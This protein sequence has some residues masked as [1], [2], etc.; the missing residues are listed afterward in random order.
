MQNILIIASVWPEPNSSAAGARTMELIRVCLEHG[1]SVTVA[2]ASALS[3]HRADLAAIGVAERV[4]ALN[5]DSF[6]EVVRE[7]A[8]DV[9]VF[10]R[11]FTEEQFGWR[12]ERACPSALRVIETSDLHSLRHV[13]EVLLKDAQRDCRNEKERYLIPPPEASLAQLRAQMVMEDVAQREIA[14]IFRCDVSLMISAF[15]MQLL[16]EEFGVPDYLLHEC[17]LMLPP[18]TDVPSPCFDE[19]AHFVTIGNFRHPPNWD[20]VLYLKHAIWPLIRRQLPDAQLHIYGAYP[21][22]KA[23]VLHDVR[24]GFH[25]LGW[26]ESAQEVMSAARVCL[27]PLRFGA[28]LKGKLAD[29]MQCGTP[30]VTTMI[31]CEGMGAPD[32]WGGAVA[33][34]NEAIADAAVALNRDEHL[35]QHAQARG[36]AILRERFDAKVVGDAL[37]ARLI[38]AIEQRDAMRA[39]NFVGAMLR[40]HLHKSTQYMGQWIALKNGN[41]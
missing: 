4:I 18:R 26:A 39:K 34:T 15:E 1:W 9:V 40:H 17:N 41:A 19:R 29:A 24:T 30:S 16:R 22:P 31:G 37:I 28:G 5:C 13:R 33:M 8:P 21:P 2:S 20:A 36:Y 10:D 38:Q 14:A 6:D 12:V 25:V 32:E 27:A 3:E 35:W 11:Y 7:L 23:M